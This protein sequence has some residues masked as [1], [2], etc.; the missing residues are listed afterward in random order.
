MSP[1]L[2]RLLPQHVSKPTISL[3]LPHPSHVTA[4]P[5][6]ISLS[7]FSL[8]LRTPHLVQKDEEE[9][10]VESP[11]SFAQSHHNQN[12]PAFL[13]KPAGPPHL[14]TPPALPLALVYWLRE[15]FPQV[16]NTLPPHSLLLHLESEMVF[17]K[18]PH[19]PFFLQIISQK[20]PSL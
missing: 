15:L 4:P 7:A 5:H 17:P 13:T 6:P 11:H 16:S 20:L 10:S 9:T 14:P 19:P 1:A 18:V 3:L 12:E 2:A 8:Q